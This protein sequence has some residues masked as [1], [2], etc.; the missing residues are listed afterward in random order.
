M[1]NFAPC[2]PDCGA[3]DP[4]C[5]GRLPDSD[6]FAGKRLA[7]PLPGGHLYRCRECHLKFRYPIQTST[8]YGTLYD[9]A[10]TNTWQPNVVRPDWDLIIERI[11]AYA[12]LGGRVLDFGCYSGGLLSKLDKHYERFGVEV[13]RDA[14]R[15][16][17][18]AAR[19]QVWRSLQDIPINLKFDVI[20][21]ADVV[22][23]VPDPGELPNLLASRLQ[24]PGVILVTTGDADAAMW[25]VFGAN[26]WYCFYPEH[27][28]FISWDWAQRAPL[29]HDW[30]ILGY[31]RFRHGRMGVS[32]R[33]RNLALASIYG[34][35]PQTYLRIC[36]FLKRNLGR[37]DVTSVPGKGITQDHILLI[38]QQRQSR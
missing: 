5:I 38:L 36:R 14:A 8:T 17:E 27:I 20:V 33:L 37:G 10:E 9:N 23:H 35:A 1:I 16:A 2:C 26:W 12:P 7:H 30:S 22:E 25:N 21:A 6:W 31:Q 13:N 34:I 3:T 32:R 4:A 28:A 15:V 11:G 19:A 24:G 29:K 18:K